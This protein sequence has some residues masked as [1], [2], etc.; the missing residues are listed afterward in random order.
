MVLPLPQC[1]CALCAYLWVWMVVIQLLCNGLLERD[2]LGDMV[3]GV[4]LLARMHS[5]RLNLKLVLEQQLWLLLP[6]PRIAQWWEACVGSGNPAPHTAGMRKTAWHY[7]SAPPVLPALLLCCL[8][9]IQCFSGYSG[10]PGARKRQSEKIDGCNPV[11]R[12]LGKYFVSQMCKC[13]IGQQMKAPE[14][15]PRAGTNIATWILKFVPFL[16]QDLCGG[17]GN[18]DILHVC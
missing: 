16:E 11:T 7:P 5:H 9:H 15:L 2:G 1:R 13:Y 14:V 3:M 6:F 4:F 12:P 10:E 18:E 17:C 8:L